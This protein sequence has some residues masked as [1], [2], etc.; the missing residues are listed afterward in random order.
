MPPDFIHLFIQSQI[1]I[2][3][4]VNISYY[5]ILDKLVSNIFLESPH[6]GLLFYK[7][8]KVKPLALI[9]PE[10]KS[11]FLMAPPELDL[12]VLENEWPVTSIRQDSY[13]YLLVSQT[14][15]RRCFLAFEPHMS[16]T[17][18]L[19]IFSMQ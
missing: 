19:G 16:K 8:W 18:Y 7:F 13:L 1:D 4:Q 9:A 6:Q 3:S 11:L 12:V 5:K 10:K 14:K 2:L 15:M 17:Y